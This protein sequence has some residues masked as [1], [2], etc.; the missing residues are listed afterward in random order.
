MSAYGTT[1]INS[2]HQR[3]VL[4][5]NLKQMI[6]WILTKPNMIICTKFHTEV[7]S[8]F[9]ELDTGNATIKQST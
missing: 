2:H 4:V 7:F 5:A 1:H 3:L 8:I 6:T 9:H